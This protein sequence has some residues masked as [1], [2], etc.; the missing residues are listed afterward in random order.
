MISTRIPPLYNSSN[1]G[2]NQPVDQS[3]C[4]E[5]IIDQKVLPAGSLQFLEPELRGK[6]LYIISGL[7]EILNEEGDKIRSF[8][9]GRV[10]YLPNSQL[11]KIRS[12]GREALKYL[13]VAQA[14]PDPREVECGLV[15]PCLLFR[16]FREGEEHYQDG[17]I[18]IRNEFFPH[19]PKLELPVRV[20]DLLLSTGKKTKWKV[21]KHNICHIILE[22]NATL[23]INSHDLVE[24]REG[25]QVTI[26]KGAI[27]KIKNLGVEE[28]SIATVY[29]V[30]T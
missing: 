5:H 11:Y 7:G 21:A 3:L 24:L 22:G 6:L 18:F 19:L 8:T 15:G 1:S 20:S 17:G 9:R 10:F 25:D 26:P 16:Y 14:N 29:N 23:R 30:R 2:D 13:V 4:T 12:T 27:W 28:L